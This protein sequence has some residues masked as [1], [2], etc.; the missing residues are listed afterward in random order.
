[1]LNLIM[2]SNKSHVV[3][4]I[5]GWCI[6]F[7]LPIIFIDNSILNELKHQK[8]FSLYP[9]ILS[10]IA[11]MGLF[12]LNYF[13]LIPK[14]L[15]RKKAILYVAIICAIMLSILFIKTN[16]L[17]NEGVEKLLIFKG[18]SKEFTFFTSM[19][20]I[21]MFSISIFASL[22]ARLT[23]EWSS[24]EKRREEAEKD[25]LS[26]EISYIKS[27]INPH[28][29]FNSLNSVYS[30]SIK[31]SPKTSEAILKLSSLMA[32][33]LE[34]AQADYVSVEK[35]LEYI[36]DYIELQ[37]LRANKLVDIQY[38]TDVTDYTSKIAPLILITFIENAFKHGISAEVYSPIIIKLKVTKAFIHVEI[39]NNKYRTTNLIERNSE[40]G[41][42]N[43]KKR[44]NNMYAQ[45]HTLSIS[46][47]QNEFIV[48][49][50]ITLSC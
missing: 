13:F 4:H 35:E 15:L 14:F 38:E 45:K 9:I 3:F 11:F 25:K 5:I 47:T 49:L 43:A 36:S 26:A 37:K 28:F 6:F 30:L 2:R 20:G 17:P 31:Q 8:V 32:Y 39:R 27:Q 18:H 7:I 16:F 44:L 48:N 12:Y 42:E 10:N 41:I 21:L 23:K 40:L 24:S 22:Y 46:E 50:N 34:D 19:Q 33:V 1:M 29:L